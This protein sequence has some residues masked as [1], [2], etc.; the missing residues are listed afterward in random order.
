M[1]FMILE[2]YSLQKWISGLILPQKVALT[3][4]A[5]FLFGELCY[6]E[7]WKKIYHYIM[8]YVSI[9]IFSNENTKNNIWS[10]GL[11]IVFPFYCWHFGNQSDFWFLG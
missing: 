3:I 11:V 10:Y 6:F 2:N 5:A 7:S 1:D 9:F 4:F 8:F